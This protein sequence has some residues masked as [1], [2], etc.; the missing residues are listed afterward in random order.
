MQATRADLRKQVVDSN[1]QFIAEHE[2]LPLWT[3]IGV[4][5]RKWLRRQA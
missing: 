2:R 5:F 3:E 4:D 1:V